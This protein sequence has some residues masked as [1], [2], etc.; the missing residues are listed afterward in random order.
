MCTAT[1]RV[2]AM[3]AGL[4]AH[5]RAILRLRW[6]KEDRPEDPELFRSTPRFQVGE[7]DREMAF[8]GAMQE[9]LAWFAN[10]LE[11]RADALRVRHAMA[12][13]LGL[14]RMHA[15][16]AAEALGDAG[17][18]SEGRTVLQGL[19]EAAPL[20]GSE[21]KA[22]ELE[23]AY[24]D[25]VAEGLARV[26]AEL[27]AGDEVVAWGAERFDGEEPLHPEVRREIEETR[28]GLLELAR[29]LEMRRS[30]FALPTEADPELGEVLRAKALER[31]GDY[32]G[33]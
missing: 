6:F 25:G 8:A 22:G 11:S 32:R 31:V 1:T 13:C 27:L 5:E 9:N 26:W 18:T 15:E 17:L 2:K 16:R 20:V 30:D 23:E 33:E 7:V 3:Y 24:L 10:L 19:C 4:T 28:N 21:G 29:E 12:G 14:W